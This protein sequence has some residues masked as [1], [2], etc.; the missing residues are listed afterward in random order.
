ML[1]GESQ[2]TSALVLKVVNTP[3]GGSCQTYAETPRFDLVSPYKRLRLE[4][5]S[6]SSADSSQA[7]GEGEAHSLLKS[8][9]DEDNGNDNGD[10][11]VYYHDDHNAIRDERDHCTTKFSGP[12]P[13]GGADRTKDENIQQLDEITVGELQIQPDRCHLHISPTKPNKSS[14]ISAGRKK[15][16]FFNNL[17]GRASFPKKAANVASELKGQFNIRGGSKPDHI[18]K[19]PLKDV[20]NLAW[21]QDMQY[22]NKAPLS[23]GYNPV[24]KTPTGRMRP[25]TAVT[26]TLSPQEM[27]GSIP[28]IDE[29]CMDGDPF[30]SAD[31]REFPPPPALD[32]NKKSFTRAV[33]L[34]DSEAGPVEL[35]CPDYQTLETMQISLEPNESEG[36][37]ESKDR[38]VH[39]GVE[40]NVYDKIAGDED[41]IEDEN[42]ISDYPSRTGLFSNGSFPRETSQPQDTTTTIILKNTTCTATDDNNTSSK[43]VGTSCLD[44]NVSS[45]S[46]KSARSVGTSCANIPATLHD[47]ASNVLGIAVHNIGAPSESSAF[48]EQTLRTDTSD[49]I[50]AVYDTVDSLSETEYALDH[51][52][53]STANEESKANRCGTTTTT[54]TNISTNNSI[55]SNGSSSSSRSTI[56][57][58]ANTCTRLDT[59]DGA[60][61]NRSAESSL[62]KVTVSSG[63]STQDLWDEG[64]DNSGL[65]SVDITI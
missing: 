13:G 24:P 21:S 17:F 22:S 41:D 2:S 23:S 57:P 48:T 11:D 33:R 42:G 10:G 26:H 45:A 39:E 59:K 64:E 9:D 25:S 32:K 3:G 52:Q 7:A 47:Q 12:G 31:E 54:T 28:Y 20:R 40:V 44:Q 29:L 51:I 53:M 27:R 14:D 63:V 36:N 49:D 58:N 8:C 43:S 16:S 55:N 61:C 38:F 60:A 4:D 46:N 1:G 5:L 18:P 34:R 6:Q 30:M 50:S 19:T 37:G 65:R 15:K 35:Y 56:N 62:A